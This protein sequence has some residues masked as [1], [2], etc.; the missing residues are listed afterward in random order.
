MEA[1]EL[2]SEVK[3]SSDETV[4]GRFGVSKSAALKVLKAL[5]KEEFLREEAQDKEVKVRKPRKA[6]EA[7]TES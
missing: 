7:S 2:Y 5:V 1:I 4:R 3:N 6:K